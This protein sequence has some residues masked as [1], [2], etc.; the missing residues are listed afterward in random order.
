MPSNANSYPRVFQTSV[1][2]PRVQYGSSTN[3]LAINTYY[4]AESDSVRCA[5]GF[6]DK[7][8]RLERKLL[9]D[10]VYDLVYADV[11]ALA[12]LGVTDLTTF[13]APSGTV[14][15]VGGPHATIPDMPGL[16]VE[17]ATAPKIHRCWLLRN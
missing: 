1:G 7:R 2:N 17:D 4:S 15:L 8:H 6:A 12:G 3:D 5:N 11:S 13:L 16:S 9:T 10:T 14:I